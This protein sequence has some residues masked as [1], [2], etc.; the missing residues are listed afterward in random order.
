MMDFKLGTVI[1]TL[2]K[3]KEFMIFRFLIYFAITLAYVIGTGTGAGIGWTIGSAG[4]EQSQATGLMYGM[5]GGFAVV[6]GV[7]YYVREYLL[8]MVK[9]GHIAVIMKHMDGEKIPSG[10]SQITYAQGIVKERFK[11]AS[12]LF[13]VDQA[14]KKVVKFITGLFSGIMS[15]LPIIPKPIVN[16]INTV[17]KNSVTYVDEIILAYNIRNEV[18]NPWEGSKKAVV[19]Y[20]QNYKTFLKNAVFVTIFSWILTLLMV[21][22][23]WAPVTAMFAIGNFDPGY[24][25]LIIIIVASISIKA[26]IIDPFAMTALMQV[27]FKVTEGQEPNPEWEAKLE[28]GSKKFREMKD[29]AAAWVSSKFGGKDKPQNPDADLPPQA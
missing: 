11:E 17:V 3:T 5:F 29:K 7:L 6:S 20:A 18:D 4:D 27:F 24:L 12:V 25:P 22:I 26:A 19:L 2:W 14:I 21:I 9:A 10:K 28:K 23:L 8:Y 1:S 13:L 16:F 15:F